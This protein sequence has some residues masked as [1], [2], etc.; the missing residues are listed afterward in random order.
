MEAVQRRPWARNGRFETVPE[1]SLFLPC[2]TMVERGVK[3][4]G[5]GPGSRCF[6]VRVVLFGGLNPTLRARLEKGGGVP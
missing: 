3:G 1:V 4:T 6:W 2:R 5:G